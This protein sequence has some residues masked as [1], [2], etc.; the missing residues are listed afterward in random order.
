M[1]ATKE[2]KRGEE[3]EEEEAF[4]LE[5]GPNPVRF[6][7]ISTI[8]NVFFDEANKQVFAVRASG[9]I[10]VVVRGLDEKITI[11]FRLEDK[12]EIKSIKFSVGNKILA[13]QR[14]PKSVEFINFIPDLS[15]SE[16]SQECKT[17]NAKVTGFCWTSAYEIVF[18]T[19][20]S[21]EFYQVLPEK[22]SLKLLKSQSLNVN[23]F[24]Y[25]PDSSVVLA[26]TTVLGNVIQ[27][28]HFK[29]GSMTKLS[30]F[31]VEVPLVPKPAKLCLQERDISMA[32]IY[33]QLFVAV[34]RHTVRTTAQPGAEVLLYHLPK[35]GPCRKQHVLKLNTTGR[36][37]V[38]VVD[39]LFIVHHQTSKTSLVFD[40]RMGKEF[41]GHV[42]I[43]YPVLP[44]ASIHPYALQSRAGPTAALAPA[45]IPFELYS[46]SWIVFQPNIII[47]AKLGCL[48]TLQLCL[49]PVLDAFSDRSRLMEF[50]LQR[51]E[52]RSVMLTVCR[53]LL[54][55]ARQESLP[56][57]A[58]VFDK[59]N[60]V[61][62][63]WL[64][65]ELAYQQALESGQYKG[66]SQLSRHQQKQSV[67]DQSTMYTHVLS[68]FT[69]KR[70]ISYK[71][72]VA[73]LMEYI[74]SLNQAQITVQ[75]YLYELVINT[76]VQNNRF[77]QLHQLLQYHVLS[78]SKP[79]ACL[80]LSL[81]SIYPPAHQLALDM[82][83]RLGTANDEIVEVLLSRQQVLG[84]VRFVRA[85][86][87]QDGASARK[88]LEAA[89][90]TEDGALFFT[91]FRFFQQRNARLRGNPR[92]SPGEHCE[93]YVQHFVELFGNEAL[94]LCT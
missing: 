17:R 31:E 18:V 35:D 92:F 79:L 36:F 6:E 9:A 59:L 87:S 13:V 70:E 11:N 88:F 20:F 84:A 25:C 66:S 7:E 45:P 89:R 54:Y 41:D 1:E 22:R 86:G 80:M 85:A 8:N 69:E 56:T 29:P 55:A 24:V 44:P 38:N 82:L 68:A 34:L 19:D 28:Y 83:K 42:N 74:R 33:G 39:N 76:L 62:H 81:E 47:D 75:H 78:D 58:A 65:T 14:T 51:R 48:C 94:A 72:I 40:I 61:Y 91:V 57:V 12:G 63:E 3:E 93:E 67:I 50:L 90:A 10:G 71:F 64:S 16:Y 53:Q 32:S 23:W 46:S 26:S 27:P 52:C 4:Y 15:S 60:Q 30:K 49:E 73:V 21:L 37:A 5:L 2:M 77:Y 43:H